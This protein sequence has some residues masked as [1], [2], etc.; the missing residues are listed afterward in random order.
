[1]TTDPI[2]FIRTHTQAAPVPLLPEIRLHQA[3]EITPLW[4]ATADWLA[5]QS[6]PPPFWAFPWAGGQALARLLLDRPDIADGRRVL[7]FATGSGLVGIAAAMAGAARVQAVEIDPFAVAAARLNAS[8]NG[9]AMEVEEADIVGLPQPGLD[10]I[11]AGDI[12]YE[13]PMADR[14]LDWLRRLAADG[15][16][17]LVGDPGRAYLPRTGLEQVAVYD[18]P[19]SR[20]LEDAEVRR[21]TVWR[22]LPEGR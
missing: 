18:V 8:L 5:A 1:M 14:V 22:V 21:T 10:L 13:R 7:D 15:A 4:H 11:L 2:A 17:V 20:E 9:V 12:C 16:E 3:T 19:T 6:L